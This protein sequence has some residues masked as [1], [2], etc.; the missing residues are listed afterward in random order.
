M[1]TPYVAMA[2]HGTVAKRPTT[3][4]VGLFAG[5]TDAKSGEIRTHAK[6]QNDEKYLQIQLIQ[7]QARTTENRGVP[8]SSPGLAIINAEMRSRAAV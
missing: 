5:E 6:S 3:P 1:A 2:C 4:V 7:M 8:G